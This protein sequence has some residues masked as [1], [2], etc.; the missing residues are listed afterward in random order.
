[1]SIEWPPDEPIWIDVRSMLET[2]GARLGAGTD[3]VVCDPD[4]THTIAVVGRPDRALVDKALAGAAPRAEVL[5][6]EDNLD[7]VRDILPGYKA[8]AVV[9]HA[10]S[11][12]FAALPVH[13]PCRRVTV[14]DPLDH[15][16]ERLRAEMERARRRTALFSGFAAGRAVSFAYAHR[17]TRTLADTSIDTLDGHRQQGHAR[18]A[19]LHLFHSLADRGITPTWGAYDSNDASKRLAI[20]LGFV[21]VGHIW[22]LQPPSTD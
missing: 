10:H 17:E 1:M 12:D 14:D 7:Y 5:A 16:P 22:G 3:Y 2:G 4:P 8:E 9:M 6:Q 15:L 20:K 19:C 21:P 13:P 11:G 18:A